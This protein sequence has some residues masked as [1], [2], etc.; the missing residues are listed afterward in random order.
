MGAGL[1]GRGSAGGGSAGGGGAAWRSEPSCAGLLPHHNAGL[2][3]VINSS[4]SHKTFLEAYSI[5]KDSHKG[6]GEFG[7]L[8]FKYYL[9]LDVRHIL[10]PK[11]AMVICISLL[12]E[13]F[14]LNNT[15]HFVFVPRFFF[16]VFDS[17]KQLG[18]KCSDF[19]IT[20]LCVWEL[21]WYTKW[22]AVW[23]CI[24]F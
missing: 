20:C 21:C 10:G 22:I 3:H 18:L 2:S 14:S 23:K 24:A 4:L 16:F 1:C 13:C 5:F 8:E 11:D 12:K 17:K 6:R 19:S 9:N 15:Y 7:M